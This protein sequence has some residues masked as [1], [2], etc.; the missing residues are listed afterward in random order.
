MRKVVFGAFQVVASAFIFSLAIFA[1]IPS[2]GTPTSADGSNATNVVLGSA[3]AF[4]GALLFIWLGR[5]DA[6]R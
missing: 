1:D 3:F 2:P 6:K 5:R 4:A